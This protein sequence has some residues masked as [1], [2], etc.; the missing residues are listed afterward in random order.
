MLRDR[1]AWLRKGGCK[2]FTKQT[3]DALGAFS[4][5]EFSTDLGLAAFFNKLLAS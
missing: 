4:C 5:D 2:R 3:P 1:T